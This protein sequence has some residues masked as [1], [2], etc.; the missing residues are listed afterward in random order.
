[1][2]YPG[3]SLLDKNSVGFGWSRNFLSNLFEEKALNGADNPGR[4]WAT[5][6]MVF[7]SIGYGLFF[8][9]MSRKIA[10]RWAN[11]LKLIGILNF[12]LIFLIATPLHDLGVISIVLTLLGL[13]TI[14]MFLLRTKLH[15]LKWCCIACLLTYYGFFVFYGL[16]NLVLS[17]ILQK[18][19]VISSMLLVIALEYVTRRE[20]FMKR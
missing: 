18:V 4:L 7:H 11:V 5:A 1:M 10:S 20:D 15:W 14:T 19:Y 9:N 8:I 6:G 16:G 12:I 3:G 13:F 17:F 2:K